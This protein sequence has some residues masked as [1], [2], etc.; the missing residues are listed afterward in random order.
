MPAANPIQPYTYQTG[1]GAINNN[2][3]DKKGHPGK[4]LLSVPATGSTVWFTGS[5]YGA[6]A[7]LPYTSAT[8]TASLSGGGTIDISK[9][10]VGVI[11]ELSIMSITGGANFYVLY[12]NQLIR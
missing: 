2:D 7:L 4:F 8:G 3:F 9:L 12:R 6:S 1:S 5:N 10:A 11:C